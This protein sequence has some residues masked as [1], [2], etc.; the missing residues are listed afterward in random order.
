MKRIAVPDPRE[1]D[2]Q[3]LFY[4]PARVGQWLGAGKNWHTL[5]KIYP[6]YMEVSPAGGCNHRCV[7]CALDFMGYRREF[8]D[9]ESYRSFVSVAARKGVRSVMF[10]GEG[11]P[12]LHPDIGRM[13]IDTRKKGLDVAVTTNGVPMAEPFLETALEHLSWIKVSL[14]AGTAR[15]HSLLHGCAPRDFGTIIDNIRR[16]VRMKKRRGSACEIGVQ[17]LLLP[18][19]EPEVYRLALK[20][21]RT[22]VDYFVVKPYSQGLY[23][24]NVRK[25][26]Y[27]RIRRLAEKINALSGGGFS[28]TF[29]ERAFDTTGSNAPAYCRCNAVPFFWA[30]VATNGDVYTCSNF[31]RRPLF[32]IGNIRRQRFDRIWEGERRKRNWQALR[33]MSTARCRVNC[34]MDSVNR[35]LEKLKH[36]RANHTFI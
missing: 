4:F 20:M 16:A 9:P 5:K 26:D 21:K 24:R 12:L 6:V 35:Y 25:V 3:K 22:G 18:E 15:T 11:E 36:P 29:R 1:I 13:V 8:L 2:D 19:N 32:R 7:F 33:R 14:D 10:G 30:Y 27:S 28:A 34:R 23:S 31:L 17:V